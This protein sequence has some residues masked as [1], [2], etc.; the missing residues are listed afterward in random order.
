MSNVFF[1]R[2]SLEYFLKKPQAVL[3]VFQHAGLNNKLKKN[4]FVGIKIHFGE[5]GNSSYINPRLLTSFIK[6]LKYLPAKCFL[7]DTNTLYRGMRMNALEHTQLALGHGFGILGIPIIIGDGLRGKDQIEVNL[8]LNHFSTFYLASVLKDIDF[9]IVL[10]HPTGH[11]LSGFGGIIKSLGMGC[12]SRQGKCLMHCEVSPVIK[13]EF[14]TG[15]SLCALNCPVNTIK[16]K[17]N[18]KYVIVEDACIGCA[19]C[20]SVC[21]QAAVKIVWSES[22]DL[23]QEKICEYA[24]AVI[25]DR[26]CIYANFSLFFTKEC[27]CMNKEKEPFI[28]DIGILV[29]DDPLAVDKAAV[30]LIFQSQEKDIITSLYPKI[31]WRHI[32]DYGQKIGLGSTSYN[33]VEV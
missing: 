31:N 8:P 3:E 11:I 20:V 27:D 14:C 17:D 6:H 15:C 26:R 25:K 10:S 5:K 16:R 9:L 33:L 1:K 32:F 21:P 24:Y 29:G 19:Q 28:P 18:G 2:G 12:A 4:D 30:D 22:Y 13:E 23:L 7:W